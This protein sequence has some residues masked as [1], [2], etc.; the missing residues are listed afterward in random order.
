[1]SEGVFKDCEFAMPQQNPPPAFIRSVGHFKLK[2]ADPAS[3]WKNADFCELFWCLDGKGYFEKDG[4][5]YLFRPGDVWYYPRGSRHCF[6]PSEGVLQYRWF[7]IQGDMAPSLFESANLH[8]G[9]SYGGDC[10]ENLFAELE[11][12]IKNSTKKQRMQLLAKGFEILCKASSGNRRNRQQLDYIQTARLILDKDFSNPGLNILQLANILHVNR[13]QLSREFKA[14]FGVTI[15]EYLRN[16]RMQKS[17]QFLRTSNMSLEEI[18]AACG[19][20]SAD[21]L[22]K[23]IKNATGKL[24]NFHRGPTGQTPNSKH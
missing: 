7:T 9:L 5:R 17:L 6:Y 18:A 12:G 10:P 4:K 11:M 21:Y 16:L 1:M 24:S 2:E 3:W 14:Q 19:Y 15:S 22:G 13:V 20:S 23:I 8:P